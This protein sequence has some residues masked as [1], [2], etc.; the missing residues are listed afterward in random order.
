MN[1]IDKILQSK[2]T[3]VPAVVCFPV[4]G[5]EV[6]L[7]HRIKTSDG[8]GQDL[9][10][11]IGGKVGDEEAFKNET[12][13]QA[14]IREVEEEVGIIP[15]KYTDVG[16]VKFLWPA[17]PKWSMDVIIYIVNA[18][19]KEPRETAVARPE[20]YKISNL[21]KQNMWEDNQ[22]WVPQVLEGKKVNVVFLFDENGKIVEYRVS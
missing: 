15:T 13:E 14:L 19:N 3:L 20:W 10:S 12:H 5:D 16:R 8:L 6:L 7:M 22:Y 4:K 18:W 1:Q 11:G 2:Q 17:K 21:P 9:I